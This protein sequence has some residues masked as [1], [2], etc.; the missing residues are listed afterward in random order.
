ML[1]KKIDPTMNPRRIVIRKIKMISIPGL[2]RVGWSCS[3]TFTI[4]NGGTSYKYFDYIK[5][6]ETFSL[7]MNEVEFHLGVGGY[8]VGGDVKIT[9]FKKNGR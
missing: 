1:K 9:F 3:P 6:R 4:E 2:S 7:S 8:E 5:K